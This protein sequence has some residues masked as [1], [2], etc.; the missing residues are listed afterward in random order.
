MKK[1]LL[2]SIGTVTKKETLTVADHI[3]GTGVWIM[4][5]PHPYSGYYGTTV[6]DNADALSYFLVTRHQHNDDRI[7]RAIQGVKKNNDY[8]FDGVPGHIS[9]NNKMYGI[10]RL[11]CVAEKDIPGLIKAFH[12]EGIDFMPLQKQAPVEAL[13]YIKKYFNTE[14]VDEGIFFDL[15]NPSFAYLQIDHH[16]EWPTFEKVT[17]HIKNNVPGESFD[18]ALSTLYDERGVIDAVRIYDEKRSVD[19]LRDIRRRYLDSIV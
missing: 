8:Q 6:P 15:H 18:A 13:I 3:T 10:I 16:F 12:T 9:F 14:E 19:K 2:P 7:I 11:R 5:T 17:K 1:R 4:E